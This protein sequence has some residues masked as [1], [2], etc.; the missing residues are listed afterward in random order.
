[1]DSDVCGAL[2]ESPD[3]EGRR[4]PCPPDEGDATALPRPVE[5]QLRAAGRSASYVRSGGTLA[6]EFAAFCSTRGALA[7][8]DAGTVG[9]FVAT[10]AGYQAKTVE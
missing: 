4:F 1:M 8:C 10:L 5:A 9:A 3:A 6:G 7:R 2:A